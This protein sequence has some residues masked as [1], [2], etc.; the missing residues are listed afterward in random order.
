M[1]TLYELTGQFLEIY[2]MDLDDE[3]KLD[4]LDSIDWNEDYENKIE[5]YI[6]V[7][8]NLEADVAA[9]KN[10]QD[11]LKKLND[12]DK[13]KIERMKTDLAASMELT[14]R[15]KVDTSLFKVSFR[16]SKSVEVDMV[17]LPERYKKIEYKADKVDLKKLLTNGEEILGAELV[18]KKNLNIR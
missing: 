12:S 2:N 3:T 18:E 17:L 16:R 10:E 4:T 9:R 8:K 1:S 14:G 6:K 15:E 7:I 13:N 5:N 11:R